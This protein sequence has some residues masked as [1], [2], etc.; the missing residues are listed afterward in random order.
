MLLN[1]SP[2]VTS[3]LSVPPDL[4]P[5]TP[6]VT[7]MNLA[8]PQEGGAT[9]VLA[10][11]LYGEARDQSSAALQGVASVVLNRA[12]KSGKTISATCLAPNQF[13]CWNPGTRDYVATI[14]APH[15]N[16][17]AYKKCLAIATAVINGNLSDNT[18]GATFYFSP[19]VTAAPRGWGNVVKTTNI[20]Q[21]Q[22]FRPV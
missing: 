6:G 5:S 19:P 20:D 18:G 1:Q 3:S 8:S 21:L 14:N 4:Q 16:D 22:F 12:R 7:S 10:Q 17:S 9:Q 13:Q 2:T 15:V 11:T